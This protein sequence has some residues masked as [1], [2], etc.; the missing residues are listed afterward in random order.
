MV[1]ADYLLCGSLLLPMDKYG[2]TGKSVLAKWKAE[3]G[4]SGGAPTGTRG[5]TLLLCFS[6][7][8]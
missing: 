1:H 8:R 6:G 7:K 2:T 5:R 4:A 3:L